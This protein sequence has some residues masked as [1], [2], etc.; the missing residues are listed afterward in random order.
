MPTSTS[1]STNGQKGLT[2]LVIIIIVA[3]LLIGGVMFINAP[4]DKSLPFQDFQ[5]GH[6]DKVSSEADWPTLWRS[7]VKCQQNGPK[8]LF[9][10]C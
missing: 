6:G 8:I 3:V 5:A 10:T 9:F 1:L 7:E 4:K 2:P